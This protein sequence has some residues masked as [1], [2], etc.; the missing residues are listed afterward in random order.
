MKT[1]NLVM[2]ALIIFIASCKKDIETDAVINNQSTIKTVSN[3]TELIAPA[4]FD[5]QLSRE[6]KLSVSVEESEAISIIS[7]F[8]ENPANGG[9]LIA[10]GAASIGKPFF[11]NIYAAKTLTN[12][13]VQKTGTDNAKTGKVIPIN[14]SLATTSFSAYAKTSVGK[15]VGPDCNTGCTSTVNNASGNLTYSSSGSTICLTGSIAINNLTIGN[16][17]TVR[18]CG[19]GTINNLNFSNTNAELII[20]SNANITFTSTT[21]IDGIFTNYGTIAT[22]SNKNFNVNSNALFTNYGIAN[23]GKNFNP[24]GSSVIVNNGT[25]EVN[26]KLI[27]SSG[28]D[29]TNYCKLIVRDDFQNNGLF[30]NYGYVK[31]YEESTIQGGSNNEFKQYSGA[32]LSTKDIQVNGTI[33]GIGSTSLIKVLGQSKGNSQGL[34]NGFQSFCDANGIEGPWNATINGGATQSC[35]VVI[36]TNSCNP[37]GNGSLTPTDTDGDGIPDATDEYPT[38]PNAAFNS[39]YP[40]RNSVATVAY[41]DLFPYKGDYDMNDVVVTFNYKIVTNAQNIVVK[42]NGNYTLL[43]TGGTFN[44]GFAVQFPIERSKISAVNGAVLENNQSKAVMV[45]FNNMR[46]EMFEWNTTSSYAKSDTVNYNMNF[47]ISNGPTLANFGLNEYNPFIWNGTNGFSRGYEIHLPGKLPTDL[48]NSA[49]FGTGHDNTNINLGKTYITKDGGLPWAISIPAKFNY[50]TERT[51]VNNAYTKF[52]SWV[53]SG[54]TLFNDW[55]TNT[56]GYRNAANIY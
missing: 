34:V 19:T 27:N 42:L 20:T 14:G 28:C 25:I 32:M 41:E 5:W 8:T 55:Y 48:V 37:E 17:T 45:I 33:T 38:D 23:F 54:G 39:Y 2:I 22:S 6:V 1:T 36:G 9:M 10:Q 26:N 51:D 3:M 11:A 44:N 40:S 46:N 18:I 24:N 21:P 53:L 7:V 49:L 12:L 47:S 16:N 50:P 13:F 43:A 35:S 29:F 56:S 30:K 52:A 31:C 4:G 15:S